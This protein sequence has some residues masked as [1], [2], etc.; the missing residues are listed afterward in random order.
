MIKGSDDKIAIKP[1][2]TVSQ[3]RIEVKKFE[4][5]KK[6]AAKHN[7]TLSHIVRTIVEDYVD[8]ARVGGRQQ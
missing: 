2:T 6:I 3:Y 8:N 4:K 7:Q 1:T 5:L